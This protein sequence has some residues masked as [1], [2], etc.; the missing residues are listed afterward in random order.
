MDIILTSLPL[1][2]R[3]GKKNAFNHVK[4]PTSSLLT[5]YLTGKAQGRINSL[6]ISLSTCFFSSRYSLSLHTKLC[7]CGRKEKS[8]NTYILTNVLYDLCIFF[9]FLL[10]IKAKRQ[11]AL[12]KISTLKLKIISSL[13]NCP[14]YFI[15][16]F[17]FASLP[18]SVFHI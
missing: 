14:H 11:L 8:K 18:P 4:T 3:S 10:H 15:I 7:K 17:E 1:L 13:V 5:V 2:T 12:G 6:Q 16:T 9:P